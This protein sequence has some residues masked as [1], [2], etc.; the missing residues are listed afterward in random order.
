MS[1]GTLIDLSDAVTNQINLRF[2]AELGCT[3]DRILNTEIKLEDLN[4]LHI[5]VVPGNVVSEIGTRET[6]RGE[7]SIDIAVR[8]R[9]DAIPNQANID[10]LF[11]AQKNIDGYLFDEK[12][13]LYMPEAAW[14]KSNLR[15][16]Y[17]PAALRDLQ[18]FTG[19]LA[20]TY[21]I[22]D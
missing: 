15:Y 16:P 4:A 19:I 9:F 3:A 8:K 12:R 7:Y 2:A 21:V 18:Q 17:V 20:V 11:L 6:Q 22:Y 1:S 13:L 5:S 10:A 14:L